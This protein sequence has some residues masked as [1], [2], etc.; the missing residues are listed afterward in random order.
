MFNRTLPA[1]LCYNG[2][3]LAGPP[4]AKLM[5]VSRRV[6]LLVVWLVY[7]QSIES[8]SYVACCLGRRAE[9]CRYQGG[10]GQSGW[11]SLAGSLANFRSVRAIE[12]AT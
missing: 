12:P 2:P 1:K 11:A 8:P 6:G 9:E 7:R 5:A 10:L 4:A 3:N